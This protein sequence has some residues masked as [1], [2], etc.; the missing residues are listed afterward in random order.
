M[1]KTSFYDTVFKFCETLRNH[2]NAMNNTSGLEDAALKH[3]AEATDPDLQLK[4]LNIAKTLGEARNAAIDCRFART[5][6]W[7]ST[8]T[9]ILALVITGLTFVVTV[10]MQS[11]QF[12]A[13]MEAQSG[14][15]QKTAD[16]QSA[17]NEDSK[18][19][20]AIGRVSVKD[21]AS[22]LVGAFAMQGFFYRKGPYR[23]QARSIAADLLPLVRDVQAFDELVTA[24]EVDST[25]DDQFKLIGIGQM[26]S[27]AQREGHGV[28]GA[29]SIKGPGVPPFLDYD[30][31]SI[32]MNPTS[33]TKM[34]PES[35]KVA[36]WELDTVSHFLKKL[37]ND[38]QKMAEPKGQNLTGVV[39][40]DAMSDEAFDGLDFSGATLEAAVL[41]RA[42][43]KNSIFRAANFKN[44]L[45]QD[46]S[47]DGADLSGIT[48]VEGSVWK[49]TTNWW[50]AKCVS[51]ELL[52]HLM[53]TDPHPAS[54]P[55][56]TD[57]P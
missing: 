53:R 8:V 36:A 27:F 7:A 17:A 46:A 30:I 5:R 39:L 57:C 49:G 14:Q 50:D 32:K 52:D 41:Y 37:W 2:W 38:P 34:D 56:R 19:K 22:A 44:A 31:V 6:F 51:P 11:K 42:R 25:N 35:T 47:L 10:S 15:F 4:Y 43:F 55:P 29:A 45:V 54:K 12:R 18:W 26:I 21:P 24:I 48:R 1:I 9:P 16:S 13:T 20:D 28:T 33:E 23:D 3:A 40:E